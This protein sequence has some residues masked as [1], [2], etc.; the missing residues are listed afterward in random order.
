GRLLGWLGIGAGASLLVL[1]GLAWLGPPDRGSGWGGGG[2]TLTVL[3]VLSAMLC[4]LTAMGWNGV[5]FAELARRCAPAELATVA[6]AT[7]FFT[8]GGS[9]AGP[10][11]YGEIL[12]L[13]GSYSVAYLALA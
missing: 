4:A 11:V 13:G 6:G 7:Q 5:F 2:T 10:V 8:F 9:M 1:A 12:R 3:S